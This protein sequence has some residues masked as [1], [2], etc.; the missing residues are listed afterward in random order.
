MQAA[1]AEQ[2][3]QMRQAAAAKE[4]QSIMEL[5]K[6]HKQQQLEMNKKISMMADQFD[7]GI[8]YMTMH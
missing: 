4:E 6:S 3:E 2:Q 5:E 7:C 8:C 1:A